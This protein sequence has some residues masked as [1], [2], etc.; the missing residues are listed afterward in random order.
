M[1]LS[2]REH[3][4]LTLIACGYTDKETAVRLKIS[5]RTVDTYI[6]TIITKLEAKNR[7][8]AVVIYMRVNPK[9]RIE[10][11]AVKG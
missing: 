4:V 1:K 2:P 11:R 7:V 9:W 8:N 6:K 5:K 10:E 3:D